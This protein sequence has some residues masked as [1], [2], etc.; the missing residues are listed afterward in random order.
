MLNITRATL[1]SLASL[2]LMSGAFAADDAVLAREMQDR[3]AIEA[4]MWRYVRALDTLDADAYAAVFAPDGQFGSGETASK[5]AAALKKMVSD[6]KTGRATREAGGA[7]PTPAMY[8]VITNDSL[9]F[10]DRD[11]A[12]Y[13]A[14][15]MT[16]FASSGQDQPP[17][18]AAVGRSVDMLVRLNGKWLIQS[19]DVAPR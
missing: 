5:G 19:R 7:S 13:D 6:L 15:W 12:R 3:A 9:E 10:V 17:R 11:H 1:A 8:H 14:Y 18:V 2:A 4:L 16:V